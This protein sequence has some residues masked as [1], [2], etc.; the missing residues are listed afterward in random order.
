MVYQS[1]FPHGIMFHRFQDS[2]NKNAVTGALT[3]KNLRKL[4]NFIGRKRILNPDEW[5][6]KL[7]KGNLEKK[8][9]CLTFDD[10]LKSQIKVALPVLEKF[11]IKAFWFIHCNTLPNNFD[12]SEIFS[13][14]I[15]KKFKKYKK[16]IDK[17]LKYINIEPKIFESKKFKKY[18]NEE[19]SLYNFYSKTELKYK[20]L[21][22]IYYPRKKFENIVENFFKDF[23]LNVKDFYKNTWLNKKDL[24]KLNKKGHMI[25]MHSFSHP[26][27]MSSL[28]RKKQKVE[29]TKNF[30]YLKLILKKRPLAMSHPLDSYN[31]YSLKILK[32]LGVLC[33]FRSHAKTFKGLKINHSTLEMA[34][35]D[36]ANILKFIK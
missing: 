9:V 32:D 34:R 3:S 21:R 29:Y 8:D 15:V 24:V 28:T 4:I 19:T 26:Y 35:E 36:P 16:F 1:T 23:K 17:F 33:G 11:N 13:I 27:R 10:G 31:K 12:K 6:S 14:L 2:K 18:Y 30:N 5:I 20:F 7:N 25:G 22:D